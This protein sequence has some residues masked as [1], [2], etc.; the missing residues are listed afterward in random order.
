MVNND[1]FIRIYG[2]KKRDIKKSDIKKENRNLFM[3]KRVNNIL[4]FLFM[5][6]WMITVVSSIRR[7]YENYYVYLARIII[8]PFLLTVLSNF[9]ISD[10]INDKLREVIRILGKILLIVALL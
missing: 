10:R 8:A 6:V 9:Y 7:G 4:N 3:L 1:N 2:S 5:L